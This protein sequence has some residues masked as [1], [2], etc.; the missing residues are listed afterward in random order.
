MSL[1]L[2]KLI[3]TWIMDVY[4]EM[5]RCF[6]L[7]GKVPKLKISLYG[8][9]QSPRNYV[10][11]LSSKL[12]QLGFTASDADPCLFVSD[13]CICLVYVDDT[14]LYARSQKDL[15]DVGMLGFLHLVIFKQTQDPI[16]PL[17]L[18]N[19]LDSHIPRNVSEV[20]L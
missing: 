11:H 14:L 9:K 19:V 17:P 12:N 3:L 15:N 13:K 4:V 7:K 18:L 8:L 6:S 20:N 5:P 1:P 10:N 16:F 2:S